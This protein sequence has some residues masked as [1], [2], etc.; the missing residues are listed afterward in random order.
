MG[1]RHVGQ[2]GL[3]LLT[4]NDLPTLASQCA[5]IIGLTLSLRLECGGVITA[6]GS[7]DC[8]GSGD[9]P[10]SAT[11]A[12]ETTG[13][14]HHAWLIF[15]F[16][17]F[18]RDRV[19]PCCLGWSQ[20]SGLQRFAHLCLPQ[21]WDYRREPLH[22]ACN[23]TSLSPWIK[24]NNPSGLAEE[25]VITTHPL[26]DDINCVQGLIL[27]P[28]LESSGTISAHRNLCLP[29]EGHSPASASGVA[30]ITGVQHYCLVKFCSFSR[31]GV[32]HVAR[33]VLNA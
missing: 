28:R 23:S 27:S 17:I 8:S 6:H 10:T 25:L 5:V 16:L 30:G 32:S 31:D 9:P 24:T 12:V 29:G 18:C 15:Y 3:K 13:V 26:R 20:T 7:L 33:L 21:C 2:A 19:L 4:S 22:L 11:Q 1:F 14:Y